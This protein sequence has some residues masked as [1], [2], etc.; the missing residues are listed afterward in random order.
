VPRSQVVAESK[1]WLAVAVRGVAG[2]EVMRG[3][4]HNE[5]LAALPSHYSRP[6]WALV[7]RD[8]YASGLVV[9][10]PTLPHHS[11]VSLLLS[12]LPHSSYCCPVLLVAIVRLPAGIVIRYVAVSVVGVVLLV[13]VSKRVWLSYYCDRR[14]IAMSAMLCDIG[15]GSGCWM[16]LV[17]LGQCV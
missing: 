3:L 15:G 4:R 12:L 11:V 7:V 14:H 13:T 10:L 17:V 8:F 2:E 5:V 9:A 6:I 16:W 1:C